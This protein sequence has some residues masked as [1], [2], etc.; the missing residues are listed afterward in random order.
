MTAATSDPEVLTVATGL[1]VA[2]RGAAGP[3]DLRVGSVAPVTLPSSGG[4]DALGVDGTPW[5]RLWLLPDRL[6]VHFLRI[7]VAEVREDGTITFDRD[8][9]AD[10]EEHLLLDHLLPLV[11]ASRGGVVLHGA[12]LQLDGRAV[13]LVGRSGAGKSTLT[14][15]LQQ[16]GW[17]VGGDDGAVLGLGEE[18]TA[19]PTYPTIRLTPEAVDLLDIVDTGERVVGKARLTAGTG[20]RFHQEPAEVAVIATVEP[21]PAGRPAELARLR[22]V[23]AHATLFGCTFHADLGGGPLMRSVMDRL[24]DVPDRTVVARLSVPRGREGLA[25]AAAVLRRQVTR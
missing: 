22:G 16:R 19:E 14:A 8:L 10:L 25:S 21:I 17:S 15:F 7:T 11:L 23:D 18:L 9:P 5:R 12:V 24:A 20:R 6:V 13:V 2:S 1:R 3:A 4:R